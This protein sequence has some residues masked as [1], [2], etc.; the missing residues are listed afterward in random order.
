MANGSDVNPT[1]DSHAPQSA[2]RFSEGLERRP[3]APSN[4]RVGRFSDGTEL[5]R[6]AS[7]VR[8]GSFADGQADG[9]SDAAEI[10]VGTFADGLCGD[11]GTQRGAPAR[12]SSRQPAA[13]HRTA[14]A[15]LG[16]ARPRCGRHAT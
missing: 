6:V 13:P 8:V 12:T 9:H 1:R 10:R 7:V 16:T 15:E 5:T 4:G 3:T 11:R 14:P 2:R